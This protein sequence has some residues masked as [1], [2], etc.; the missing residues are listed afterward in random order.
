[1]YPSVLHGRSLQSEPRNQVLGPRSQA[2]GPQISFLY[3]WVCVL[4]LAAGIPAGASGRE[5]RESSWP[6]VY[7]LHSVSRAAV[8]SS[9]E[10]ASQW[11]SDARCQAI[12]SQF[13]DPRER[14]LADRL[15]S[16]GVDGS[17][18]LRRLF[19][20]DGTGTPQCESGRIE[21]F[22]TPGSRIVF[23]CGRQFERLWLKN[24]LRGRAVVIHEALHSLG[25]GENP[26]TSEEITWR[27]LKQCSD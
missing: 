24:N 13:R 20:R 25:L 4:A 6:G 17:T 3:F 9:L 16:L 1:M 11:L 12:F 7:L 8:I 2:P 26:P 27:V 14:P 18:Y 21:A 5:S 23:I 15:A 19:F 22:T 10:G